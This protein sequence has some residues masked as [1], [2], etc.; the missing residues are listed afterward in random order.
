[1]PKLHIANTFFEWELET[2]QKCSLSEAFLQ[3]AI[4]RQ[5]QFLPALY[6]APNEGVL[7]S[8]LPEESYWA[9]LQKKGIPPPK[10]FTVSDSS[11]SPYTKI[12]SWGASRLVAE[13]AAKHQ[14]TY[15]MPEWEVVRKINSK[16]F[17]FESSPKLPQATLLNDEAHTKR[18]LQSFEG[19]KVLKTCYGVSG[20]GHLII[21]DQIPWESIARF[22][23][24]Q[25]QKQLPVIAEPW[26]HRVLD[27]S[28]QW[29]IDE[30]KKIAYVGATLCENNERGQY[31]FNTVGDEKTLFNVHLP[32]LKEHVKI[33]HP[34]LSKIAELGFFGNIGIDAMLYTNP[35]QLDVPILHPIVEINAR[36]TMGWVALINSKIISPREDVG[37]RLFSRKGPLWARG[38]HREDRKSF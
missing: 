37:N 1:M 7:L 31:R 15:R 30:D 9:T 26:M 27:F 12:D 11:F 19:R 13:F 36:K 17:S 3:H 34:I 24:I 35:D 25:W 22:L 29:L 8:D 21:D 6:A 23:K 18:W 20:K 5:L 10:A 33:A 4:F 32:F 2:D 16:Q 38:S 14:L 28:T